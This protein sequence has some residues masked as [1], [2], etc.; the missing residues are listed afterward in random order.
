M[1][2]GFFRTVYQVT[3]CIPVGKVATYGQIAFLAG[4]PKAARFV[5]LALAVAPRELELPAHRVIN[6]RGEL[7]PPEIFDG[8]QRQLLEN[9]G[10][11]FLSD[12]RINLKEYLWD[13]QF[14]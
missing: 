2:D 4:R 11:G 10:V 8:R 6:R 13:S 1:K 14:P 7:A 5:G 3:A 9:E 12:G